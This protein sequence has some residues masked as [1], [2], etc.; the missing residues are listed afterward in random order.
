[1]TENKAMKITGKMAGAGAQTPQ[2]VRH[3]LDELMRAFDAFKHANNERLTQ[4]DRRLS[5][6]VVT[7]EK[8]HRLDSVI[9]HQQKTLDDFALAQSRPELGGT[10]SLE[11]R[12]HKAAFESYM[13]K[14]ITYEL[15]GFEG[16]ALSTGNQTAD[17]YGGYIVSEG[18]MAAVHDRLQSAS[19][20][21]QFSTVQ[22]VST[23]SFKKI[24]SA[25]GPGIRWA[26]SETQDGNIANAD[27]SFAERSL[28]FGRLVAMP[29]A[30]QTL[31]GDSAIDLEQWLA[32]EI[33]IGFAERE[34]E[35]FVKGG[36]AGTS[37]SPKGFLRE[38]IAAQSANLASDNIGFIASGVN[39]GFPASD[40]ERHSK[41]LDIVYSLRAGNR[42]NGRW[43]MNK[44]TISEVRRWKDDSDN[45]LWQAPTRAGETARLLDYPVVEI[46]DMPSKNSVEGSANF[47]YPMAFGDWRRGY[48]VADR[49]DMRVLRD[50]YSN[51]PN[52]VFY[53][54][55]TIGGGVVDHGAIKLM[56]CV[57]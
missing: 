27:G 9:S 55:K 54:T 17:G 11:R 25:N 53:T 18:V 47:A 20:F 49:L 13:R 8:L 4:I 34:T 23:T 19:P 7:E 45:L 37:P 32:D 41:L 6:D 44:T 16:K 31:L 56:K 42:I 48:L 39:K 40:S 21:R 12:E 35:A 36:K 51:K 50:P 22:Q 24:V 26:S 29:A 15:D 14:G 33:Y 57:A 52:I 3:A 1:M 43:L 46:E 10:Q 28:S 5:S 2:E 30:S 38:T